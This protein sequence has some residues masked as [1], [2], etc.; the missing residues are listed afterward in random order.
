MGDTM[1]KIKIGQRM[2]RATFIGNLIGALLFVIFYLTMG[3]LNGIGGGTVMNAL[4]F[5]IFG[6]IIGIS[7]A[8]GIEFSKD[9]EA[10]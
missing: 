7:A 8:I 2:I 1:A 6:W 5:G 10:E 9:L 3:V 4:Y